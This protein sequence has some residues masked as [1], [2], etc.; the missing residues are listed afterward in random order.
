MK[1]GTHVD[2]DEPTDID[3]YLANNPEFAACRELGHQLRWATRWTEDYTD[4]EADFVKKGK[5]VSCDYTRVRRIAVEVKRGRAYTAELAERKI[6]SQG[7]LATGTRIS[8]ADA[9][10]RDEQKLAAMVPAKRAKKVTPIRRKPSAAK[11]PS[12]KAG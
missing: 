2:P 10:E 8:R 11:A 5:C 12:R 9:R 4:D 1:P 3:A 7:Y 6:Y